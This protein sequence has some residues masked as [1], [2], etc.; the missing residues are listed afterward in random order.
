MN[1]EKNI[2]KN[3]F[4][5]IRAKYRT[6]LLYTS[7][8][9]LYKTYSPEYVKILKFF[10]ENILW[11]KINAHNIEYLTEYVIPTLTYRKDVFAHQA[12]PKIFSRISVWRTETSSDCDALLTLGEKIGDSVVRRTKRKGEER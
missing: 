6:C 12:I 9:I 5:K 7:D 2:M 4:Y 10:V 1:K 8:L 11:D 3:L